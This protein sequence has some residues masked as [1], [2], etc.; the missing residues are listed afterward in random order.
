M[1][2]EKVVY[3]LKKQPLSSEL[4]E[5]KEKR[6]RGIFVGV[7]VILFLALGIFIGLAASSLDDGLNSDS[8]KIY[9]KFQEIERYMN[10]FWLYGDDYEDL[11]QVLEDNA[12]YGMTSFEDDP[13][14][15]YMSVEDYDEFNSSINMNIVGI[16]ITYIQLDD[17][18]TIMRVLKDSP[19][20]QGGLMAGDIIKRID[21]I[22]I[23]GMTTDEISN[24]ALGDEGTVV[25]IEVMRDGETLSFDIVRAAIDATAYAYSEDDYVVLDIDSFGVNTYNECIHYLEDYRDYEKL[26][27]DLRDNTGG[28]QTSVQEVAHLFLGDDVLVM[29]QEFKDGHS[30]E[31]YTLGSEYYDNFEEIVVLINEHTASAAEVLAIALKE[32]HPNAT[33]MGTTTFGKGVVQTSFVLD[34]GS[35]IKITSSKWLSPNGE[36]INGIGVKPDVE[37]LLDDILY[38]TYTM[39]EDGDILTLD[40]VSPFNILASESLEFLGYDIARKD[41]YFDESLQAA[42]SAFQA[43][44][45]FEVSGELDSVTYETIISN[46]IK[47]WAMNP[48]KDRQMLEAIAYISE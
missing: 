17:V 14:T 21:G 11:N 22:D 46:V 41:G 20:E 28:Y 48:Q 1:E 6:K 13:Y 23:S 38:E 12:F 39:M 9:K 2:E 45:G 4:K 5:R 35:V 15:S 19:A 40:S 24:L 43:D 25:N 27:I 10:S 16:G 42:I 29:S 18:T 7:L 36:W 34:D 8:N 30:E 37:V 47:E 26:I 3:K 33:L 31:Y 44:K 32:Q